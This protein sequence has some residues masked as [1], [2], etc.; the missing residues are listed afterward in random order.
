MVSVTAEKADEARRHVGNE[1]VYELLTDSQSIMSSFTGTFVTLSIYLLRKS[2]ISNKNPTT[3]ST[4]PQPQ[5]AAR[6]GAPPS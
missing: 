4:T 3:G 2:L 6:S 5:E 1:V